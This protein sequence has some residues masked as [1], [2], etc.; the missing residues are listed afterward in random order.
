MG[1]RLAD[2]SCRQRWAWRPIIA[3]KYRHV[4]A[5]ATAVVAPSASIQ[6]GEGSTKLCGVPRIS[7][8]PNRRPSAGSLVAAHKG[9][10]RQKLSMLARARALKI[11]RRADA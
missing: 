11:I 8:M 10:R 4:P 5:A 1:K 7:V 9:I 2:K 6:A 3:S